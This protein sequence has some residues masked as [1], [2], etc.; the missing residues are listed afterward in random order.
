MSN[1]NSLRHFVVKSEEQAIFIYRLLLIY[2]TKKNYFYTFKLID[3]IIVK[4]KE[5]E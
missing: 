4:K 1:E 5:E 3:V 2:R